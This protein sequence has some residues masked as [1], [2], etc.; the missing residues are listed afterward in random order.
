MSKRNV[1][2]ALAAL[3]IVAGSAYAQ[4]LKFKVPFQFTVD[5]MVMP[6]GYYWIESSHD[7]GLLTIEGL[8]RKTAPKK[9]LNSNPVESLG[10]QYKAKL[11]FHCYD[12]SCFLSQIWTGGGV[13]RYLTEDRQERQLAKQ[14]LAPRVPTIAAIRSGVQ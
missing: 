9:V 5:K 8:D 4:S 12:G 3:L 7:S 11:I 10:P 14:G 6:A 13:G 1:L 2:L